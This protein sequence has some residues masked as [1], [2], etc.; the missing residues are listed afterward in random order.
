[1]AFKYTWMS[2]LSEELD[3]I[4]STVWWLQRY[5]SIKEVQYGEI[6][7]EDTKCC[8]KFG[9]RLKFQT[10]LHVWRTYMVAETY[11]EFGKV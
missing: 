1:M 8:G 5:L 2:N 10:H 7:T 6:L 3:M 9:I 11:L 4:L